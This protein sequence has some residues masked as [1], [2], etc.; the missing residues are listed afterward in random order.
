[1]RSETPAPMVSDEIIIDETVAVQE[2]LEN[3]PAPETAI[4]M[5]PVEAPVEI[6]MP[7]EVVEPTGEPDIEPP[8]LMGFVFAKTIFEGVLKTNY[9]RLK[10]VNADHPE[11][12]YELHIGEKEPQLPFAFNVKT[13]NPGYFYIELP[14]GKYQIT[15]VSIPVGSATA[16]EDINISFEVLPEQI[17]YLGTLSLVG[18]K[19]RIKLGGVPVIRPGFEYEAAVLNE[20]D[21]GVASFQQ[22]FPNLQGTVSNQLM[23]LNQ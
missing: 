6:E 8:E 5:D 19:E 14:A 12:T 7:Q 23:S 2:A 20:F 13:V 16:T 21:E 11:R 22:R 4:E 17:N 9:V 3:I 18:T 15:S 1:M 10:F